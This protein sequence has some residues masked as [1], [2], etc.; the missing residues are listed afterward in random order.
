[1]AVGKDRRV[2]IRTL[3]L[4]KP[5][6][7]FGFYC[8]LGLVYKKENYIIKKYSSVCQQTLVLFLKIDVNIA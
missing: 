7:F 5:N 1:M 4:K 3:Y 8:Y 2:K 6:P